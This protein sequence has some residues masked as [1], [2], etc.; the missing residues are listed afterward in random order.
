MPTEV[1]SRETDQIVREGRDLNV[2]A[3]LLS[4]VIK[5]EDKLLLRMRMVNTANAAIAW[6]KVFP[7]ES[8]NTFAMQD[9]ITRD[10]TSA[11]G[12]WLIGNEKKLLT[13]RQTDNQEALSA[14]MR[15]RYYWNL[16][17]GRET[18]PTAIK[19]F[20]QA[21]ELDPSFAEAYAGRADC[22]VLRSNV[23]YGP[24]TPADA[25][26]QASYNA[27]KAI[28]INPLLAE[29]HT[30]MGTINLRYNW[31]W[32]EAERQFR[33]ALDINPDYAPAHFY[34]AILLSARARFDESI[35]ESDKARSLDPDSA[36]SAMN[37]GRALY[38]ARR[39]NEAEAVFRKVLEKNPDYPQCLHSLAYVL[40]QQGRSDEAVIALEK[41][42]STDQ[43]HA[44]AALGF[45][46]ARAGRRDDAERMLHFLEQS[47]EPLPSHEKAI[48]Y[49]GMRDWDQ[50]F[51]FLQ[52][53]CDERFASIPFLM[54]D[55]LYDEIR[56]DPRFLELAKRANLL[57]PS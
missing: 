52:K 24:M 7:L 30:S 16:K 57:P 55:P 49:I 33:L 3:V 9:D 56:A 53:S 20:D 34:Y 45:A 41:L 51:I 29:A 32:K 27:K 47:A 6:E 1:R 15:G 44:A 13:R 22:Y 18:I 12:M 35:S 14:Y 10:V 11:L 43:L 23:L 28:E 50:A 25:I 17:R 38:Y 40:L 48:I 4:D 5:Q 8:A 26:E 46:Y 37:Y 42:Y 39:F 2:E 54:I 36:I 19:F 31:D 21:I